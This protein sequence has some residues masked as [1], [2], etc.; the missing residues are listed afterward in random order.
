MITSAYSIAIPIFC[1]PSP[2]VMILLFSLFVLL[3]VVENSFVE[4]FP[5]AVL[6]VEV[7][8]FEDLPVDLLVDLLF[9]CLLNIYRIAPYSVRFSCSIRTQSSC[10][11]FPLS[12][13]LNVP[14]EP[15]I[16][17]FDMAC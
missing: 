3:V 2:V 17:C 7:E 16:C 5:I 6:L 14:Q 8:N 12:F 13:F 11:L 10:S 15:T 9:S 1:R 4:V